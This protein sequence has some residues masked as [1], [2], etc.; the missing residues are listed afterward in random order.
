VPTCLDK[1]LVRNISAIRTFFNSGS[2]SASL[3]T[4]AIS[5]VRESRAADWK[6]EAKGNGQKVESFRFLLPF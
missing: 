3:R 6:R 5:I 4:A 1:R 2:M